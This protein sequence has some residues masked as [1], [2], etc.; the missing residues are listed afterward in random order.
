[1]APEFA[2][3]VVTLNSR[4]ANGGLKGIL[5]Y[6]ESERLP[7]KLRIRWS[8]E[9]QPSDYI[10]VGG[11][12]AF[13]YRED[14]D[15]QVIPGSEDAAAI[16]LGNDRYLWTEGLQFGVSELMFI[17]ILPQGYTLTDPSPLPVG[18]KIFEDRLALYWILRGDQ[19]RTKVEW[20]IKRLQTDIKSELIR[21]NNRYL[22]G[23]P[24]TSAMIQVEDAARHLQVPAVQALKIDGEKTCTTVFVSY[25]RRDEKWLKMLRTHLMPLVQAKQIDVWDDTRISPGQQWR[26][27]IRNAVECAKAAVLLISPDFMASEFITNN[28]LPP[29]LAAAQGR[30]V[31]VFPVIVRPC[32]LGSL[33]QFQA[34][35]SPSKPLVD[36]SQ[37]DRDRTW[38]RLAEAIGSAIPR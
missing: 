21:L 35:N 31:K 28:E 1:M 13:V 26:S 11:G 30:G 18:T 36:M 15:F 19:Q 17:L 32:L 14:V 23:Q 27:E 24:E 6:V 20:T 7:E 22:A 25:S 12:V 10:A 9:G 5:E 33:E 16:P 4:V 2:P 37:G 29:L 3:A 8:V 34:V 38:I